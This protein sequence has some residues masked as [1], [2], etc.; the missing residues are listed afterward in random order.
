MASSMSPTPPS[1][2]RRSDDG[3]GAHVELIPV[4]PRVAGAP[5][6]RGEL[7]ERWLALGHSRWQ[8]ELTMYAH[9]CLRERPACRRALGTRV[10]S[11]SAGGHLAVPPRGTAVRRR[12]APRCRFVTAPR[13]PSGP[14]R[15]P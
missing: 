1:S 6:P 12:V 13:E 4:C 7:D 11:M 9:G 10:S 14:H 2:R 15:Q 8:P 3:G 5:E